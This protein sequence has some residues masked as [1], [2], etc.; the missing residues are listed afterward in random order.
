MRI[1]NGSLSSYWHNHFMIILSNLCHGHHGSL[2]AFH[3]CKND[4]STGPFQNDFPVDL[5]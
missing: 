4:V 2:I 1:V 5:A 3:K